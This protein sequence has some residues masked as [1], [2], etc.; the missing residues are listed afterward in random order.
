MGLGIEA[1]GGFGADTGFGTDV[2]LVSAVFE[3][4]V[5]VPSS[6]ATASSEYTAANAGVSRT[7][8]GAKSPTKWWDAN[9]STD[10][11]QGC[12]VSNSST[13]FTTPSDGVSIVTTTVLTTTRTVNRLVAKTVEYSC[14]VVDL[15]PNVPGM[16]AG[17]ELDPLRMYNST[18]KGG[19]GKS[20]MNLEAAMKIFDSSHAGTLLTE[21]SFQSWKGSYEDP[22]LMH[23][24]I[25]KVAEPSFGEAEFKQV[26]SWL[27]RWA[28]NP[29]TQNELL[30]KW[31]ERSV[32][33]PVTAKAGRLDLDSSEPGTQAGFEVNWKG[34]TGRTPSFGNAV[35]I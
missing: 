9:S 14:D 24:I 20:A 10:T 23:S 31:A 25:T 3:P 33:D 34:T 26:R 29:V 13:A 21:N 19:D 1:S 11:L 27:L 4:I 6:T 15:D 32:L 8:Y 30:R 2:D 12:V 17:F 7:T 5:T 18:G 28:L 16:Q 35:R 22:S